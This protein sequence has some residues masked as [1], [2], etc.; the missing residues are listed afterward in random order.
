[1]N[2]ISRST[3]IKAGI[4]FGLMPSFPVAKGYINTVSGKIEVSDLGITLVHEHFLVDFIG[5]DKISN[6]RWN[7]DEV[8]KKVLPYLEQVKKYGVKTIFDCTPAWLGRD[9]QLLKKLSDATGLQIITNT[10]F[11]GAVNNKYLPSFA[12]T[13]TA[14]Q[15][16]S[17]WITEFN[18]GIDDT[19]VKP[20]FIK[21]GVNEG[22]LSDLHQKL[23][24]A[25]GLTHKQTGLTICSHTGKAVAALEQIEILK[26]L[27]VDPSAF[28][29]VHAQAEDDISLLV[30][31]A[32]MGAWISLDGL[33]WGDTEKYAFKIAE[34]KRK[35]LLNR[36]LIS[37]D[38]GW[39]K[40]G[41]QDGGTFTG[42]TDIF[43]KLAPLISKKDL[44]QLLV[45]NP[46]N[47]FGISN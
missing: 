7:I 12:F 23:V 22:P 19:N 9:V 25:A 36:V 1:M 31:A 24:K 10:G 47:A 39:Y 44:R 15:I 46:P 20:G 21:I 43:K 13:E 27:D 41:E 32:Q 42:F 28:V 3:F 11:Y 5:A 26:T 45:K 14:E 17:R 38:A 29:W 6:N 34:L 8:V 35:Q 4:G 30:K 37:H 40:P 18:N 33:G 16:A 2:T